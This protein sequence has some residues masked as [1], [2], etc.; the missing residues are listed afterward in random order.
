MLVEGGV[1]LGSTPNHRLFP[2]RVNE[3][4]SGTPEELRREGIWPWHVQAFDE[5]SIM[6]LLEHSGFVS[7]SVGYPTFTKGLSL[8]ARIRGMPFSAA[9]DELQR[10]TWSAAD[11]EVLDTF[12][13]LFSG[14]SFVFSG[15]RSA[16]E[17]T[18]EEN[19]SKGERHGLC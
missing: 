3:R 8:Y 11:F 5:A 7:R 10:L 15:E 17:K 19:K 13:P 12:H 2:Y 9:M 1:F 14:Y 4:I 18:N 16:V 6:E